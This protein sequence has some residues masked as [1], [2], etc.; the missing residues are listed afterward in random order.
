[1]TKR[2]EGTDERVISYADK[3]M[4]RLHKKYMK[5]LS[6]G[7]PKQVAVTAVARELSGFI[8]GVMTFKE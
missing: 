4:T 1:M 5:L 3:A 2:R 8:W 7:K 6:R